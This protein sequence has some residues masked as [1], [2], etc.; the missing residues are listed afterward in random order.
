MMEE[1]KFQKVICEGGLISS[2]NYIDLND[3]YPGSGT[4]LI[5]F[6]PGLFGGYRSIRG[7]I[8]KVAFSP[9]VDST[10]GTG[11]IL[12]TAFYNNKL[13]VA[14]AQSAGSVYRFYYDDTTAW[15]PYATGLTLSSSGVTKIRWATFNFNGTEMIIF[16]DGVNNA[17]I[18]DGTNWTNVDP[19]GTGADF[20]NAGGNQA[21]A[22]PKYVTVYKN[23]IFI[24]GDDT[25]PNLVVHCAPETPY[26][27]TAASGAGQ[28]NAG[29]KVKQIKPWRDV[30]YVFGQNQIKKIEV[31][32]TD[33]VINDVTQNIGCIASDSVIE[34]GGDILFLSRDGFRPISGTNRISDVE[35]ETVSKNIQ[36]DIYN[37]IDSYDEDN[38][39]ALVIRQKSQ[40]RFFFSGNTTTANARGFIAG[41]RGTPDGIRWEWSRLE[42]FATSCAGSGYINDAEVYV[43]GTYD[44]IVYS[45]EQLNSSIII[46]NAVYTTP[47][48]DCGDPT[49]RKTFRNL[50]IY[51]RPEGNGV[52]DTFEFNLQVNYNWGKSNTIVP[53]VISKT[54]ESGPFLDIP[55]QGSS[56]SISFTFTGNPVYQIPLVSIQALI[57]EFSVDGKK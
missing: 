32:N 30:N 25:Y 43:H 15:V 36:Q 24:S 16:V 9:T 28:I 23:H 29:F 10:N 21:I 11:R 4:E 7:Y 5:N 48:F 13:I 45:Q 12:C 57:I 38:L 14:R 3:N 54:G 20:A 2:Q 50:R 41:L 8:P 40:A 56:E 52:S 55:L 18:F 44:G 34:F 27:W 31:N 35:I 46:P 47:Y 26:D 6:E 33:F 37:A 1:L 49:I 17:T 39:D 53:A 51:F 42:G 19:T 22:A